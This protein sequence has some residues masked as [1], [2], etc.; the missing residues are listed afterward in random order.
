MSLV[1]ITNTRKTTT[2]L[3]CHNDIYATR[4]KQHEGLCEICE[5]I[6]CCNEP[7]GENKNESI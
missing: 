1:E 4:H 2:C 7:K 5:I 3:Y 6:F